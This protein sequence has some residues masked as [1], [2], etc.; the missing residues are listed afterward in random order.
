MN[1]CN[2][3]EDGQDELRE[4]FEDAKDPF[5]PAGTHG[6]IGRVEKVAM[7]AV[8]VELE[9]EADA[10]GSTVV[11]ANRIDSISVGDQDLPCV[12]RGAIDDSA[13]HA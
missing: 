4:L 10:M 3:G 8:E 11:I 9:K 12:F 2:A 7:C 13:A 1:A 6:L 5:E